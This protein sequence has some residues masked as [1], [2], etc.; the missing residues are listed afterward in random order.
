MSKHVA[1]YIIYRDTVVMYN[2]ALLVVIKSINDG[3]YKHYDAKIM[4]S[5]WVNQDRSAV[6]S[7]LPILLHCTDHTRCCLVSLFCNLQYV[8]TAE[9]ESLDSGRKVTIF[10]CTVA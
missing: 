7:L 8:G 5:A 3:R 6:P 9:C 1:V 2:C 10:Q 4:P